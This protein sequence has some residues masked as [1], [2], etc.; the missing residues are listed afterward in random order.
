MVS[1]TTMTQVHGAGGAMQYQVRRVEDNAGGKALESK[2]KESELDWQPYTPGLPLPAQALQPSAST[3]GGGEADQNPSDT[4]RNCRVDLLVVFND[5]IVFYDR[6][7]QAENAVRAVMHIPIEDVQYSADY[8]E[9]LSIQTCPVEQK[10]KEAARHRFGASPGAIASLRCPIFPRAS[11]P[12]LY[13]NL[14][15]LTHSRNN[16]MYPLVDQSTYT[17]T[18]LPHHINA[19]IHSLHLTYVPLFLSP[20][21]RSTS[22]NPGWMSQQRESAHHHWSWYDNNLQQASSY[23]PTICAAI[24]ATFVSGQDRHQLRENAYIDFLSGKE[25]EKDLNGDALR[26]FDVWRNSNPVNQYMRNSAIAAS[27]AAVLAKANNLKVRVTLSMSKSQIDELRAALDDVRES[28]LLVRGMPFSTIR[29]FLTEVPPTIDELRSLWD[30]RAHEK[31][32]KLR[33]AF[34]SSILDIYTY[35]YL[36]RPNSGHEMFLRSLYS[37]IGKFR[38]LQEN[39]FVLTTKDTNPDLLIESLAMRVPVYFGHPVLQQFGFRQSWFKVCWFEGG[40]GLSCKPSCAL[41]AEPYTHA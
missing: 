27:K 28:A 36:G 8:P 29:N 40:S 15:L 14:L 37:N 9:Q 38:H 24:E 32:N 13:P 12:H 1:L 25:V 16:C 2:T 39:T 10:N 5:C 19:S 22:I 34:F 30:A 33:N 21:G 41:H 35:S 17:P 3:P 23:C 20:N 7:E 6:G 26:T 11:Y 4:G 18:D 31:N